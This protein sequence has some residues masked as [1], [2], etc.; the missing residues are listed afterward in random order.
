ML[1]REALEDSA[2]PYEVPPSPA[3]LQT[4][5]RDLS[6]GPKGFYTENRN[7]NSTPYQRAR[8]QGV[9]V[10]EAE[11]LHQDWLEVALLEQA[12]ESDTNEV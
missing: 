11:Y 4:R 9:S 2:T 5:F 10:E 7:D 1:P 6:D 8:L 12:A 3:D